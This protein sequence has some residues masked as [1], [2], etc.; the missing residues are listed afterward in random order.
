M[1]QPYEPLNRYSSLIHEAELEGI[2]MHKTCVLFARIAG[3]S[4]NQSLSLS[5][6]TEARFPGTYV[7]P[8]AHT[9]LYYADEDKHWT[10]AGPVQIVAA[11]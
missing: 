7:A 5:I 10:S 1:L 11:S 3:M 9:Y 6:D 4:P 8:V 2:R